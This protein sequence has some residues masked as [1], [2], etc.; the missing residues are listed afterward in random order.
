MSLPQG[1]VRYTPE[2]YLELE[3]QAE[4]R[5]EYRDG[6]IYQMSGESLAH[7]TICVNV[8]GEMRSRLRGTPCQALSPNMKVRAVTKGLFAY[9]DLTVVCGEPLFHDQKKDV[10]LNPSVIF[11]VQS[12]S[13][14][15]YD[16]TEKF[17][18]YRNTLTSL[19][20]YILV[21]QDRPFVEHFEKRADG[22]WVY[23]VFD[24]MESELTITSVECEL[25]LSEIYDRVEFILDDKDN[26][27]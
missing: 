16:R 24:S 11:E 22:Q 2:Q 27:L 3:R 1:K 5:H 15:R 13:T 20:D 18:R 10:L 17:M 14:E 6:V 21:A 7:S 4:T 19:T 26:F 8:I 9:P 23:H 12:P 25:P